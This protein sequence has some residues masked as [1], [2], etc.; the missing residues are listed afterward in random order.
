MR[1]LILVVQVFSTCAIRKS[2]LQPPEG[3]C[4]SG[5]FTQGKRNFNLPKGRNLR[6][7]YAMVIAQ[8]EFFIDINSN[9]W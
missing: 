1:L 9:L 3:F 5:G 8:V 2:P 7:G 6:E 4:P